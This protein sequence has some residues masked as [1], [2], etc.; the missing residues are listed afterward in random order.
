MRTI[1]P[2]LSLD[3]HYT[4]SSIG[5]DLLYKLVLHSPRDSHAEER[6]NEDT[7]DRADSCTEH[8]AFCRGYDN[9]ANERSEG[10]NAQE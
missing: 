3:F 6:F 4:L 9:E 8:D 1:D 2:T 7:F 5:Q 10:A